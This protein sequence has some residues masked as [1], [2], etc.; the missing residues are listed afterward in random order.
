MA[1]IIFSMKHLL[2][3]VSSHVPK[4]CSCST[5]T[6]CCCYIPTPM[7][8]ASGGVQSSRLWPTNQLLRPFSQQCS[9]S[10]G[11]CPQIQGSRSGAYVGAVEE[12]GFIC[13]ELGKGA[14]SEA[15]VSRQS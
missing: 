4:F 6:C 12:R 3:I 1:G 8:L 7:T 13:S 14:T 9:H 5:K 2:S 15:G 11:A 10:S